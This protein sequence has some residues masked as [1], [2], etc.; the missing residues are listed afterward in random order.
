MYGK[1][2]SGGVQGLDRFSWANVGRSHTSF[3][4]AHLVT[5]LAVVIFVCHTIYAELIEYVGIRQ[6]YLGSPQH[7]VQAFA[8]ALLV[9]DIPRRFLTISS[10]TRLY[11]AFPGGV[12]TVW[13][14]RD[15]SKL[16]QKIRERRKIAGLLE[17]AET[18]L[19][20]SA[21]RS[22]GDTARHNSTKD[23]LDYVHNQSEV[24]LWKRYLR[25][26]DRDYMRLPIFNLTWMS[27][28]PF[29]RRRVDTIYH[30][31]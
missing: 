18:K 6:A 15:L 20:R 5:A 26:N 10:L 17:A 9:T 31:W 19:I 3:H 2:A 14:N 24:A 25:E 16:S 4:W 8:N 30:C 28:I 22:T 11:G 1:N 29:I 13:I 7:R 27:S 21:I 23:G 12:R